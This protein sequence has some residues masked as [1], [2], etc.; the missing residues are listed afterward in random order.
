MLFLLHIKDAIL[1][2]WAY[3]KKYWYIVVGLLVTIIA[4]AL[5]LGKHV[6]SVASIF[7]QIE[8]NHNDE[9]D[10]INA[11]RAAANDSRAA[12][13]AARQRA[14]VDAVKQHAADSAAIDAKQ[15]AD[16]DK[17]VREQGDDPVRVAEDLGKSLGVP[18]I[19][20]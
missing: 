18:V 2:A 19:K 12:N 5:T 8:N 11:A 13:E 9:I 6:P 20:H 3:V 17:M 14:L 1:K 7:S 16:V 10:K 15:K 4:G